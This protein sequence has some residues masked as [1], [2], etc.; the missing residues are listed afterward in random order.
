MVEEEKLLLLEFIAEND[1][2]LPKQLRMR[3]DE[4]A[5]THIHTGV[6]KGIPSRPTM[7]ASSSS[8]RSPT[9]SS[10]SLRAPPNSATIASSR[11]V[12]SSGT[13]GARTGAAH[14]GG[15]YAVEVDVE[16]LHVTNSHYSA[17]H[18]DNADDGEERSHDSER[19]QY[20]K[21]R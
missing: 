9:L 7:T 21:Q 11:G 3:L 14:T 17:S 19:K 5:T 16:D 12:Y 13:V 6:G 20:Q 4:T 15:G 18:V 8:R 10:N 1:L 2:R